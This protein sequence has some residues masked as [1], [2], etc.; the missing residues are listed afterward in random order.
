MREQVKEH[1]RVFPGRGGG[2]RVRKQKLSAEIE[3]ELPK[4]HAGTVFL[5]QKRA[6]GGMDAKVGWGKGREEEKGRS[7][8]KNSR[9]FP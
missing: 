2:R 6:R 1:H 4:Q 5:A 8:Q 7:A 9:F 3:N